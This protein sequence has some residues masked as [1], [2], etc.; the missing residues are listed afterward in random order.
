MAVKK[1]VI[2]VDVKLKLLSLENAAI[3]AYASQHLDPQL[4]NWYKSAEEIGV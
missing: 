1:S 3:C 2:M 4:I